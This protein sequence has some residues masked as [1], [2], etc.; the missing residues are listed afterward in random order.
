V[1]P[2]QDL[3]GDEAVVFVDLVQQSGAVEA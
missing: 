3:I 1:S 2:L